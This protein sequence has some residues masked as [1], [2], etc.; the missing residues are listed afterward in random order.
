MSN[1]EWTNLTCNPIHL[2]REDGSHGGHWCYKVSPGCANCYSETQNQ[3]NYFKFAS[4]L[5]YTGKAPDNLIFDEKVMQELLK[6]R[7]PKKV[8]LGS[9]TDLFGE[10]VPDEWIDK[11]FAYMAIAPQHTFQILTKRPERMKKYLDGITGYRLYQAL[12]SCY[13]EDADFPRHILRKY[14][15]QEAFL[16]LFENLGL[17]DRSIPNIWLGTSVENQKAADDRI[18]SLSQTP[19]AVRFLSCEPLLESID[20]RKYLGLCSGCQTCEF[21]GGHRISKSMLGWIIAGGESGPGAR[22]CHVDSIRSIVRQCKQSETAVFVKQLGS[23]PIESNPY[24]AGIAE[25]HRVIRLK[26][27]KGGNI[28][29]FPDDLKIREFP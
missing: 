4:K 15:T 2:I 16:E 13:W 20:L 10:W 14:P 25:T 8:F 23:T 12:L 9:M 21:H 17:P 26:D 11:A 24:I 6:I 3:S 22:P 29:E 1:I 7:S 19:A 18:P 27:R 28:D 5:P